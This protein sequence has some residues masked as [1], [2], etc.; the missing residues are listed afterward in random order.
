MNPLS[1]LDLIAD[2]REALLYRPRWNQITGSANAT[3][4]LSQIVYWWKRSDYGPFY[5]FAAPP[6][7]QNPA[8]REGDS[9]EEELGF[10]RSQ[11]EGARRA[12]AKRVK[13]G[14]VK[15]EFLTEW[16]V[17]Y[18]RDP[19]NKMFYELNAPLVATRLYDL[20]DAPTV[21]VFNLDGKPVSMDIR[22]IASPIVG[23]MQ[24]GMQEFDNLSNAGK[25][26]SIDRDYTKTK[27]T[28]A[29]NAGKPKKKKTTRKKWID[30]DE[31]DVVCGF[32]EIMGVKFPEIAEGVGNVAFWTRSRNKS[33]R[34]AQIL[35]EMGITI[36]DLRLWHEIYKARSR[37]EQYP[38]GPDAGP[39]QSPEF[40]MN[41]I[42]WINS[43]TERGRLDAPRRTGAAVGREA[44]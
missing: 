3:I 24:S 27:T 18:W 13:K 8:Y 29:K 17:L 31:Y 41:Y 38:P 35:A 37:D 5:K 36:E 20:Y 14:D 6:A 22:Q 15:A 34:P 11:F 28:P 32:A 9:W 2:D 44:K 25:V 12:I 23:N 30:Y 42:H 19:S 26:Q 10:S 1:L 16:F 39:P 43:A 40:I 7:T 33:N 4:L 21:T